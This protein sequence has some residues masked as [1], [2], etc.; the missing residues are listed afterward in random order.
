MDSEDT[1]TYYELLATS[2]GSLLETGI[3]GVGNRHDLKLLEEPRKMIYERD[4]P[5]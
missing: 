4:K 3:S 1:G 2:K 5:Y